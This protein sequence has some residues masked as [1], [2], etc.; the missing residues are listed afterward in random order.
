VGIAPADLA[1]LGT[2]FY[3]I[4]KARTH[5]T[6]GVGIGLSIAHGIATAHKGTLTLASAVGEGTTA[7]LALPPARI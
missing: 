6:G 5:E 1:R 7:T 4:D 2:R 3:R